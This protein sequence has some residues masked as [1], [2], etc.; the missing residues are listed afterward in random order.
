[1]ERI[2]EI[3]D[4]AIDTLGLRK[5]MKE[6]SSMSVWP[7]VVG[8]LIASK[9]RPKRVKGSRLWVEVSSSAWMSELL[10]L[11]PTL[12]SRINK[13]LGNNVIKDIVFINR[14]E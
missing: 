12:I 10:Y 13:S 5:K 2:D 3:V 6:I 8:T 9:T 14:G 7:E 4:K 11:K 1:M